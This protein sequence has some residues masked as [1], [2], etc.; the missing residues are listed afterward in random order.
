MRVAI[1][2]L[3]ISDLFRRSKDLVAHYTD[4]GV[5]PRAALIQEDHTRW[6]ISIH[7]ANGS[8]EFQALLFVIAGAFALALLVGYK[9]RIA[10]IGSWFLLASLHTR[11]PILLDG[12]DVLLRLILFWAIFLPWGEYWSLDRGLRETDSKV[13]Q[14]TFSAATLA[15]TMQIVSM[16][17]FSVLL[18]TGPEWHDGSAVYYTL[19]F[20]Q[21]VTAVGSYFRQHPS[22]LAV[23]THSVF[24]FEIIGPL[25]L[26]SPVL[27]APIRTVSILLLSLL[28]VGIGMCI[29]IGIFTWIAPLAMLGLLPPWFW[30]KISSTKNRHR[31]LT[32][33]YDDGCSF[34]YKSV[35]LLK[36]FLL[37]P[38][39]VTTRGFPDPHW[40]T[41]LCDRKSW[42][43]VDEGGV[44]HFKFAALAVLLRHSALTC[45]LS[46]IFRL[47]VVQR[48]GDQIYEFISGHRR[49]PLP[50]TTQR[51]KASDLK[52]GLLFNATI[53][54][55]LAYVLLWNLATIPNSR[56]KLTGR[57][58]SVG[59]VLRIDQVWNMFAP[60]PP[61][62]NGWFVIPGRLKSGEVVDLFKNDERVSW[63]RPPSVA[64]LFQ[65]YRWW[66]YLFT[67][68]N[69]NDQNSW[70]NYSSY[71]CRSWN[72][73]HHMSETLEQLRI[74]LVAERIR[75]DNEPGSLDRVT[76]FEY[77][78]NAKS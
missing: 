1:A 71:L 36:T 60:S 40:E 67:L 44:S 15:Y 72:R 70:R 22:L 46:P 52:P 32:I 77:Q 66:K 4:F 39:T 64:A 26:F 56:L 69:R 6:R 17:W 51:A 41:D 65:S 47:S 37:L 75:L 16:Y 49:L 2:I 18:K 42:V 50:S 54:L 38:D 73:D 24:W 78:C 48:L 12:G 23:L 14:Q 13:P 55:L 10:T 20:D 53:L 35:H 7:L 3:L 76:L 21:F 5:L 29:N 33:Y 19:Y 34:C 25:L 11:N 43:V 27:H 62:Y 31:A 61:R 8:W 74:M 45:P 57:A 9:T 59:E 63:E 58:R 28:H 30:E 68:W